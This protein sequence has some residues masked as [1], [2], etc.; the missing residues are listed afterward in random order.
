MATPQRSSLMPDV[1]TI[2]EAGISGVDAYSW[3]G[4]MVP[5]GTPN[6]VI[7]R[8]HTE[9]VKIMRMRDVAE[10][11]GSQGAEAVSNTPA[12]FRA[13]IDSELVKYALIV[14]VSGAK[15]D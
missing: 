12:E 9:L 11:L 10:R 6:A 2:Y 3:N 8:L 5:A 14:K 4:V 13:F 1:P 15:V 7:T